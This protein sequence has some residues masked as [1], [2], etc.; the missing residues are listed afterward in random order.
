MVNI[1]KEIK[2]EEGAERKP[3]TLREIDKKIANSARLWRTRQPLK[4]ERGIPRQPG[5]V[6]AFVHDF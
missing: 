6:R 4:K 2:K 3:L 1:N 5:D